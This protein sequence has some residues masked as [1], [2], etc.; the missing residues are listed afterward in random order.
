[1]VL[2]IAVRQ[3]KPNEGGS[4]FE[5]RNRASGLVLVQSEAHTA[6]TFVARG[7]PLSGDPCIGYYQHQSIDREA[8]RNHFLCHSNGEA[9]QSTSSADLVLFNCV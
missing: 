6:L 3:C 5:P 8:E 4:Y 7:H 1:M 2:G 9:M